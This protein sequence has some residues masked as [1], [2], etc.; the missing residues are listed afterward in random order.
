MGPNEDA[1]VLVPDEEED[2]DAE[3]VNVAWP[4]K[5]V[6]FVN[7]F[8]DGAQMEL[9][10][11]EQLPMKT[12]RELAGQAF[13]FQATANMEMWLS[14]KRAVNAAKRVQKKYDDSRAKIAKAGKRIQDADWH[15]EEKAAKI[16]EMSS[17]L[18]KAERAAVDAEEVRAA[19]DEAKRKAVAENR[20]MEEFTVLLDKE[21]MKQCEDLIYRFKRFNA[22]K[23]LN[24]N[25]L[26]DPPPLPEKV[27]EEMV[28]VY[29]R[30]DA[31]VDSSSGSES[32]GEEE[33]GTS[34]AEPPT[35]PET[36]ASAPS[37]EAVDTRGVKRDGPAQHGTSPA[38]LNEARHGT[39]TN[40]NGPCSAQHE[41]L[42][43]AGI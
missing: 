33:E 20:S 2:A 19:A 29:L 27:T 9:P 6:P 37:T 14:M 34:S 23:K 39:S 3:P 40:I 42:D 15:A 36:E 1:T 21:V 24:L 4:Q 16:A 7:C 18:A 17:K 26:C 22:D 38:H 30:E 11:L 28:E 12:V 13:R 25:F 10:K 5:V 43:R 32:S 8:I 31:E 41:S 35:V